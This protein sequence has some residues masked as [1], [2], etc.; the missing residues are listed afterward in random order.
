MNNS[1]IGIAEDVKYDTSEAKLKPGDTFVLFTDGILEAPDKNNNEY[2]LDKVIEQ[3]SNIKNIGLKNCGDTL[4]ADVL[5]YQSGNRFD[6][7]T[8]LMLKRN[9]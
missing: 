5:D 6:D 3:F 1:C 4:I 2:G 8:L 7:I 9:K